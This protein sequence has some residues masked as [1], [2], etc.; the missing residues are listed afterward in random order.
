MPSLRQRAARS[1]GVQK[2]EEAFLSR[3][4]VTGKGQEVIESGNPVDKWGF[5]VEGLPQW[6]SVLCT[7]CECFATN[8]EK[9][10]ILPK[11]P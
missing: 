6:L 1:E 10:M 2:D 4:T 8:S 5:R 9:K 7:K 3:C 11:S